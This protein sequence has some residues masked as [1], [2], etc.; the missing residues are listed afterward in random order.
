MSEVLVGIVM[1]SK[2]DMPVMEKATDILNELGIESEVKV[3]SAHRQPEL[4]RDYAAKAQ[5]RGLLAIICGAGMAAHL[6]G[7]VAAG[8]TLPVIGVPIK[9]GALDG[10]DAL[11]STVMMPTG[12][13]VATVAIDGAK[14]AAY[15]AAQI[16]ANNRPELRN[17][18][19][20]MREK[21]AGGT[22]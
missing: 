8:T 2:S 14:N 18:L 20:A 17:K 3:M 6:A 22:P 19:N 9:S 16:V 15:L 1:G 10:M 21:M 4:V 5:D 7:A 11:L 13:P 12:V